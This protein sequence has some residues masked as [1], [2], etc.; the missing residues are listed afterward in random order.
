MA[1]AVRFVPHLLR[2]QASSGRE[3]LHRPDKWLYISPS[4]E[5]IVTPLACQQGPEPSFTPALKGPSV[6]TQAIAVVI[7][8]TPAGTVRSNDLQ[9]GVHN[10]ERVFDQCV[11]RGSDAVANQFQKSAVD[12][13][14]RGK[15]YAFAWRPVADCQSPTVGIFARFGIIDVDR[16]DSNIVFGDTSN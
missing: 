8:A 13:F 6:R 9:D 12:H 14:L 11:S 16:I 4:G 2:K 10:T 5:L 7:V 1:R 3:S 15:V